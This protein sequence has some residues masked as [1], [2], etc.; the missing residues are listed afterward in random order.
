MR[1]NA[2]HCVHRYPELPPEFSEYLLTRVRNKRIFRVARFDEY[3][4]SCL[5]RPF[6]H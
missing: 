6:A 5:R 3:S 1:G 2:A 4:N